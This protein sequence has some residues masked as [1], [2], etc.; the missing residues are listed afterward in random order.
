MTN[1]YTLQDNNFKHITCRHKGNTMGINLP[2]QHNSLCKKD[3]RAWFVMSFP[4]PITSLI[5][6]VEST[7]RDVYDCRDCNMIVFFGIS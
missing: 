7:F 5:L 1:G 4:T 6:G 2:D 3:E